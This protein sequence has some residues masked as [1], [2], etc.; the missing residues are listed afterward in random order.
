MSLFAAA[1]A[2]HAEAAQ[3]LAARMR[4]RTLEEFAGQS[5]LLGEGKLLRRM[6]AADRVGSVILFGPPGTGKTTLARLIAGHSDAHFESLNA[7][8]IGVKEVRSVL[9]AATDRLAAA[10]RRTVLFLD[11]IHRFSRSQQDVL[12]PDVEAGRVTLV[13]ATTA[14][15]Y[16]ALVG[17]LLSRSTIFELKPLSTEEVVAVL[18]RAL[19]DRDR[20]LGEL[21]VQAEPAAVRF[22]AEI[23]EGDA[24]RAL[25]GLEVAVRSV[26][27]GSTVT[28]ADAEESVQRKSLHHDAAG[29]EHYDV[30]SAFIKSMRGSDPDATMYWLA[31]MLH[32]GEDPRFLARRIVICASEDVGNADPQALVLAQS[33]ASALEFVGMPEG[34]IPLAQAA[35]YVATAPKSNA[36]YTAINEALED[37]KTNRVLPVPSHLKDPR[38]GGSRQES[39]PRGYLYPHDYPDGRIEQDYLPEPR[40]F[41]EPTGRGADRRDRD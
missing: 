34:R 35:V 10:G 28:L 19:A 20:G 2:D 12:L 6:L 23:C 5:H 37:V 25:T 13:G 32:A 38:S 39:G 18:E 17:P 14:N 21:R 24:R 22:L 8:A 27:P 30:I 31:R 41:Y 1:E 9:T 40:S 4:P 36:S 3:P 16:F 33:A 7:A 26:E 15:P 29:D 11:E